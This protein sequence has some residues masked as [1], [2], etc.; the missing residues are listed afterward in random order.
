MKK[1]IYLISF[2]GAIV[3]IGVFLQQ[4][5]RTNSKKVISAESYSKNKS[6]RKAV[7]SIEGMWCSSCAVGAQ[8]SLKNLNGVEDAYVG[9][10]KDLK[11]EGWVVYDP[12]KIVQDKIIKAVEPYKAKIVS[13][14]IYPSTKSTPR[15]NAGV[16][17]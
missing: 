15:V 12:E 9:F 2:L 1:I 11:G 14:I 8:Y 3:V 17:W 4:K 16:N 5:W 6:L 7:L 10:T 13:D